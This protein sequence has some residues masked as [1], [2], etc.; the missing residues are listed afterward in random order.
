MTLACKAPRG[1]APAGPLTD[2]PVLIRPEDID[3]MGHVNNAVYL[4]WVQAAVIRHWERIA[5]PEAVAR[6][7]WVALKHEITYRRPAFLAD[8]VVATTGIE[9]AA[10][11]KA[12]FRTLIRRG[13]DLLAEVTS[14]WCCLDQAT[15]RPVRLP[16]A[17][18]ARFVP[19]G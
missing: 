12:Q 15:H 6:H 13:D 2:L 9:A 10:G 18:L 1:V 3:H 19:Q 16:R 17:T 8:S 4:Q 14:L 7:L 5:D 11:A